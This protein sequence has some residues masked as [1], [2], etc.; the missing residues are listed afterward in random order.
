MGFESV[1]DAPD[2][3]GKIRLLS[4]QLSDN[5]LR[6]HW[7]TIDNLDR[8][9]VVFAHVV[10][11]ENTLIGQGDTSPDLPTRYW[12]PGDEF[13]TEH[14][15]TYPETPPAGTYKV[16]IGWYDPED[17]T[18]LPVGLPDEAYPLTQIKF[19]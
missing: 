15:L 18:R 14:I 13:V 7:Q 16:T 8:D 6:I 12:R 4:Y 2:F 5:V 9:Y 10:D 19:E 3:G 17:F 11:D 1:I